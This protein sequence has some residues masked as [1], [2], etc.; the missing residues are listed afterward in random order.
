M[1]D[2]VIFPYDEGTF[3]IGRPLSVRALE[4]SLATDHI[5]FLAT[6][7]DVTVETPTPNQIY[8]VGTLAYIADSS[9][10][11]EE[12]TIKI[13]I[14]GR[15]RARAIYV[16]ERD[17]YYLATLHRALVIAENNEQITSLVSRIV[18]LVE[19]YLKL[20]QDKRFDRIQAVTQINDFGRMIDRLANQ[21]RLPIEDQ[22]SLLEIYSVRERA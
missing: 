16:E 13:T 7:H 15:E 11:L 1:R 20:S 4:K 14:K 5:V 6:Q 19:Q 12:N 17:G 3:V 10:R 9:R 8:Q 21:I 22:Q 18:S 2:I